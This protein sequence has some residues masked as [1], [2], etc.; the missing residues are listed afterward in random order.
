MNHTTLDLPVIRAAI[1]RGSEDARF[2]AWHALFASTDATSLAEWQRILHGPDPVL[3]ILCCRFLALFPELRAV[4]ALTHFLASENPT[5]AKVAQRAWMQNRYAQKLETLVDLLAS[6]SVHAQRFAILQLCQSGEVTY[7]PALLRALPH[8]AG[9]LQLQLLQGLRNFYDPSACATLTHFLQHEEVAARRAAT[10]ALG[11]L[12]RTRVAGAR[13][14]IQRAL[15]DP[16]PSV[17][18]SALWGL[19][20]APRRFDVR[21]FEFFSTRDPD[22]GVREEALRGLTHFPRGRTV[23]QL[24][25]LATDGPTHLLRLRAQGSLLAM[26]TW[27]LLWGLRWLQTEPTD[28][29]YQQRL[30]LLA[31]L[32]KGERTL[33]TLLITELS[34]AHNVPAELALIEAAGEVCDP[35]LLPALE[36]E[37][38]KDSLR[39]YAALQAMLRILRE[40]APEKMLGLL[41]RVRDNIQRQVVLSSVL[42]A[43]RDDRLTPHISARLPELLAS[44]NLNVR[45]LTIQLIATLRARDHL[46][47]AIH[48]ALRESDATMHQRFSESLARWCTHDCTA[49]REVITLARTESA[50]AV[51]IFFWLTALPPEPNAM[52]ETLAIV[53]QVRMSDETRVNSAHDHAVAAAITWIGVMLEHKRLTMSALLTALL[54]HP[55]RHVWLAHLTALVEHRR[56]AI[57][58]DLALM[59]E[60]QGLATSAERA[61]LRTLL[62]RAAA[63]ELAPLLT[64]ALFDPAIATTPAERATVARDFIFGVFA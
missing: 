44:D 40:H 4:H 54:Q 53:L 15:R 16:D 33:A 41:E 59:Q 64:H 55:Q 37:F 61:L 14:G 2:A 46:P 26:P 43:A 51:W 31:S 28:A 27:A 22:F 62:A 60:W 12:H 50:I 57:T 34:R 30:Y 6:P 18:Q 1:E 45:Y 7:L 17:R 8:F 52:S 25:Q 47:A 19:R 48:A 9:A 58:L 29:H 3:H 36:I 20:Q 42:S 10:L 35:T 63:P 49:L 38:A 13:R 24:L 56:L 39:S 32:L 11:T 23:A 21:T 5:V